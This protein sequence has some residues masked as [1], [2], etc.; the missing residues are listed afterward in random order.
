MNDKTTQWT[1]VASMLGLNRLPQAWKWPGRSIRIP[2]I[3][4]YDVVRVLL[5]LVL[6]T[7]AGLKGYQLATE[8]TLDKTLFTSRWLLIAQVEFELFMGIFLLS[9]LYK[10]L[11][12]L[13]M[14]VC[15]VAFSCVTLYK[16]LSGE[17]SCGCFGKI[18]INP[19]YTF[20]FDTCAIMVLL[21]FR[22][23]R[24]NSRPMQP[25]WGRPVML[26]VLVLAATIS[27][28]WTMA[29][30]QPAV[31]DSD[32]DLIGDSDFIVLEPEAWIGKP[33]PLLRYI[34]I[35]HR[36]A[37][38]KWVVILYHHDCADCKEAIPKYEQMALEVADKPE[39]PRFAFIEVPPCVVDRFDPRIAV[40]DY[41]VLTDRKQWFVETPTVISLED[42]KVIQTSR[43]LF[44]SGERG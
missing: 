33:L 40:C 41:G 2:R 4:G 7:A 43:G 6:L 10:R 26:V 21:T 39:A 13:V 30:Y 37:K 27:G 20:V 11:V 5:G 32:G 25:S 18:E 36:L 28:G 12:W 1:M 3:A 19:W 29:R 8:P 22:P 38:G 44:Q 34:D 35:G 9:G 17:A 42:G 16:G 15:F 24:T 31:L 14:L 23:E